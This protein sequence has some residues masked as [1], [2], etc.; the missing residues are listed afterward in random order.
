MLKTDVANSIETVKTKFN[1]LI[2][3]FTGLISKITGLF[4]TIGTAVG[5][6][7]GG[8]FKGVI[9]GALSA[10]ENILNFPIRSIN[11]LIGVINKV[12]GI[13]LGYLSTFS[14]P[15]LAKGGIINQPG[16]GVMLGSAIG[17]EKGREAV[18]PLQDEQVLNEIADAIGSRIV[19]NAEIINN[20]N[21]RIISRELKKIDNRDNFL[22]NR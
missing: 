4:K 20:M 17:G 9:N 1:S 13:N 3:F 2:S 12:P 8:A 15:R 21:G 14:L 10:I 18:V 11:N 19:I 16:R 22:Y 5:N 7:I 6:V